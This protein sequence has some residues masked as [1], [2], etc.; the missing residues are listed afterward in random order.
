MKEFS[1]IWKTFKASSEIGEHLGAETDFSFPYFIDGNDKDNF[2]KGILNNLNEIH[3]LRGILVGYFDK[4]P[5]IDTKYSKELFSKA[6]EDLRKHFNFETTE[7][8][9]LDISS[10]IRVENGDYASHIALM[11]G[12]EIIQENSKIRFDLCVDLYNMLERNDY[13]NIYQGLIQLNDNL[14]KIDNDKI[15]PDFVEQLKLF[16]EFI[17]KEKTLQKIKSPFDK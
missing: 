6:I 4:P 11:T 3:L 7:Q 12:L 10:F 14:E 8:L 2:E 17:N 5:T 1:I 15:R 16:R 9:I 13:K